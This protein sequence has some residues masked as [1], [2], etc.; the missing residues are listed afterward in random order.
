M[1]AWRATLVA[2]LCLLGP[3]RA[4]AEDVKA[5][6]VKISTPTYSPELRGFSPAIGEYVYDVSWQGIP[7]AEAR[8]SVSRE[9]GNLRIVTTARTY[10]AIDIFYKMRYRAESLLSSTDYLPEQVVIEQTENSKVKT[11]RINFEDN[12]EIFAVRS[13]KGKDDITVVRFLSDNFTLEPVAAAFLA[14]S[15]NWKVGDT[16]SFDIF[17]GKSR[18]LIE[19]TAEAIE[20][21]DVNGVERDV[22]VIVPRVKNLTSPGQEKKLKSAKLYVTADG[23]RDIVK[24]VSSAFVGSVTTELEEFV[25]LSSPPVVEARIEDQPKARFVK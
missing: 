1:N 23:S 8:I 6:L 15:L 9:G 18:Y 3:V 21:M 11:T 20:Q 22:F 19:L 14:R 10:R 13:Q 24:I 16:R 12:G 5:E 25:P 17:N 7:A 2:L 4:I